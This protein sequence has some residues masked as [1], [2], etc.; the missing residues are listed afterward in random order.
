MTDQPTAPNQ[1][2]APGEGPAFEPPHP[3]AVPPSPA[4]D[5]VPS[6]D[7]VSGAASGASG[8]PSPSRRSGLA[9]ALVPILLVAA[10]AGGV[11]LDRAG[12]LPGSPNAPAGTDA[13]AR[14]TPT[15]DPAA[16]PGP[17]RAPG[18][19][20]APTLPP[21]VSGPALIEEAWDVLH[22]HYVLPD[23]LNDRELAYAAIR[24][25]TEAV[26]DEG[27]TM[28]LTPEELEALE[29]SLSG[30]FVGIGVEVDTSDGEFRIA[31]VIPNAPAEEA[32]LLRGDRI[33]AADGVPLAGLGEDEALS[34][35]RGPEGTSVVLTIAREGR[36]DFEVTLVRRPF[37]LELVSW[38]MVPGRTVALVRLESFSSGATDELRSALDAARAA[39]ATALL[40][41]LRGN[42]GGYVSEAVGVTSQFLDDGVVFI[43]RDRDGK[44]EPSLV[45]SGGRWTDLPLAVLVDGNTASSAEIVSSAIQDAGRGEV[46]GEQTFGTGTVLARFDLEDG[47]SLRVGTV[48]WLTRDGRPLWKEG[49][50]PDVVVEL[51]EDAPRLRPR[52]VAELAPD[53][54]EDAPDTQVVRGLE[55]LD[56]AG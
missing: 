28:F 10:F 47:S 31:D 20:S 48:L 35:V 17:T 15:A 26:G 24:A 41:D 14:P 51:D 53:A 40:L 37:D 34:R 49:L 11:G 1:T 5:P 9:V 2:P 39:G 21:G 25:M 16:T 42:P 56:A 13:P 18:V 36:P 7:L 54:V 33:I 50:R 55:V 22:D 8:S 29:D 6:P 32:G 4:I 23:E 43:T 45:E 52:D 19:T 38:T 27:H 30:E 46:L 12:V 44:E 3:L